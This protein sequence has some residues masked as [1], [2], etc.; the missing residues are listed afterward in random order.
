MGPG[1]M[2]P[3]ERAIPIQPAYRPDG[4]GDPRLMLRHVFVGTQRFGDWVGAPSAEIIDNGG[5]LE[6]VNSWGWPDAVLAC[7]FAGMIALPSMAVGVL[8]GRPWLGTLCDAATGAFVLAFHAAEH[9][10]LWD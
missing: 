1:K 9:V 3:H 8:A 5:S 2:P 6:V 7:Y 10:V 4:H